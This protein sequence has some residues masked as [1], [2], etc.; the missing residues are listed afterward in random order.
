MSSHWNVGVCLCAS[1]ALVSRPFVSV[2]LLSGTHAIH[3]HVC[4]Q[5]TI[6]FECFEFLPLSLTYTQIHKH[7]HTHTYQLSLVS[8]SLCDHELLVNSIITNPTVV[9]L[10]QNV[11]HNIH[12]PSVCVCVSLL[13]CAVWLSNCVLYLL[14]MGIKCACVCDP[15]I[16]PGFALS[17]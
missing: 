1:G 17:L 16:C 5:L 8:L 3:V 15:L 7:T 9:P 14:H 2:W 10:W 13:L 6:L 11:H 4:C 12:L